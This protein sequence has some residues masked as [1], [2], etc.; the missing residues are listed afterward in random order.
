MKKQKRRPILLISLLV[1]TLLCVIGSAAAVFAVKVFSENVTAMTSDL[2]DLSVEPLAEI[3]I[4]DEPVSI[5]DQGVLVQGVEPTGPATQAGIRRGSIIINVEGTAVNTPTEL[6]S[7][8][9][10]KEGQTVTLSIING[11]VPQ[12]IRVTLAAAPPLL[13][14]YIGDQACNCEF[15]Q[16]V[17][18][19]DWEQFPFNPEEFDFEMDWLAGTAVAA[20]M[21]D[22]P[23]ATAGLKPDD[24]IKAVDGSDIEFPDQLIELLGDLQ[25]G[26]SVTLT[27]LRGEETV[28]LTVTLAAHPEDAERAYLGIEVVPMMPMSPSLPPGHGPNGFPFSG[29]EGM[30]PGGPVVVEVVPDTPASAAG[31]LPDDLIKAVDGTPIMR[32]DELIEIIGAKSPGDTVSLT[33]QRDGE[34][35]EVTATLTANPDDPD[36]A[37]LGVQLGAFFNFD[38]EKFEEF[39]GFDSGEF[40]FPM[41]PPGEGGGFFGLP[42]GEGGFF[43]HDWEE[44]EPEFEDLDA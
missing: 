13:G 32:I 11:D 25:P 39:E 19:E 16:L 41:Q 35:M 43:H 18:P 42:D 12:E 31:L 10:G 17:L 23:A 37:Y 7:Q 14:I 26:D 24:I 6:Q 8:L 21:A 20:V 3:N 36:R 4:Q 33:V 5:Y 40:P 28:E 38:M 15:G 34:S 22:S 1:V 2:F 30:F 27:V 44:L 9:A 29:E